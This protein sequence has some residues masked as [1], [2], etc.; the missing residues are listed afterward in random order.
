MKRVAI[1]NSTGARFRGA[2]AD[3]TGTNLVGANL[4]NADLAGANLKGC[5]GYEY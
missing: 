1:C 2:D 5:I 4:T 3:L